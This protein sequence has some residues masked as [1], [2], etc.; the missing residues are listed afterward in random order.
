MAMR[1]LTVGA[2]L[3][4][5]AG[6]VLAGGNRE[7][8]LTAETTDLTEIGTCEPEDEDGTTAPGW[9]KNPTSGGWGGKDESEFAVVWEPGQADVPDTDFSGGRFA[10]CTIGGETGKTP[11]KVELNVLE[12]LAN[13][14]FCVFASVAAGDLLIGCHNETSNTET[15]TTVAF[16]FPANAF[17]SGQDVTIKILVTGNAWPSFSTWGQLGV[18]YIKI[19]GE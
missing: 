4:L 8:D 5:S 6:L 14:D 19:L 16:D 12:G 15:W 2:I 18:D 7:R 11:K 1:F 10:A 3:L 13:D 17:A 9:D